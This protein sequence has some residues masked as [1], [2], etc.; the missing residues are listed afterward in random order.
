[1]PANAFA[2]ETRVDSF[3]LS[4]HDQDLSDIRYRFR[5][6]YGFRCSDA[7]SD[8]GIALVAGARGRRCAFSGGLCRAGAPGKKRAQR[9]GGVLNAGPAG[10]DGF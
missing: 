2:L 5:F 3:F 4:E 9:A 10:D 1:M 7:N 8:A 6:R